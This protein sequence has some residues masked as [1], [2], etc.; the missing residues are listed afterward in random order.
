MLQPGVS[1]TRWRKG[2]I[3]ADGR[4]LEVTCA[5]SV[6]G[7]HDSKGGGSGPIL[8]FSEREWSAFLAGVRFGEFDLGELT[9]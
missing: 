4:I 9:A 3:S 7:L 8:T 5:G 2:T 6:I 1:T